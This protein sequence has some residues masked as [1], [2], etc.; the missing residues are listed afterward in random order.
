MFANLLTSL[1]FLLLGRYR[2]D[3]RARASR[4]GD[5]MQQVAAVTLLLWASTYMSHQHIYS[6]VVLLLFWPLL[7]GTLLLSESAFLAL[8]RRMERGYLSLERTLLVGP[9]AVVG[10]WLDGGPDPRSSGLDAVGYL[11]AEAAAGGFAPGGPDVPRLGAPA[12]LVDVVE[13]YRIAQVVFWQWPTGEAAE[14]RALALLRRRRV[15]LR[16]RVDAAALLQ[17]GAHAE[18]FGGAAS[19][20]LDPGPARPVLD[21][22]R[23]LAAAGLGLLLWPLSAPAAG[24]A[25]LRHGWAMRDFLAA[26][27]G[28]GSLA[29]NW[30][31]LCGRDGRPCGLLRQPALACALIG[32]SLALAGDP[33]VPCRPGGAPP[34]SGAV[35]DPWRLEPPVAGLSGAWAGAGPARFRR[36]LRDPAGISR[37]ARGTTEQETP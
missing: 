35:G 14:L 7:L 12:D 20:V 28:E 16:W 23:R 8:R 29:R 10:G 25:R 36:A 26:P 31:L 18:D 2:R 5:R 1:G 32:G 13:R 30:R 19:A 3:G 34:P 33:L 4:A 37:L 22:V 17:A 11:S 27:A 6:R 9:A 21:G 24:L 15:R